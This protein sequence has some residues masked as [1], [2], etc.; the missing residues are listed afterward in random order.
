MNNK[1]NKDICLLIFSYLKHSELLGID[2]E[3]TKHPLLWKDTIMLFGDDVDKYIG[4]P[5]QKVDFCTTNIHL[6]KL[7]EF[8]LKML[9]IRKCVMYDDESYF[10]LELEFPM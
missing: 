8:P 2:H 6:S 3:Y 9:N 7:I 5:L 4:Y 10:F 1:M